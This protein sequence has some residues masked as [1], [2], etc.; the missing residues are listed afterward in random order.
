MPA[1]T[2]IIPL[3]NK[4]SYIGR[5]LDSVLHQ[6]FQDFEIIVVDDGSTDNGAEVVKSYDDPRIRLIR[7]ENKGVSVARNTG[8]DRATADFIAFLDADD[9]WMP[10]QLETVSGLRKKF[11]DAGLFERPMKSA[12]PMERKGPLIIIICLNRHGKEYWQIILKRPLAEILLSRHRPSE[13]Q[14]RY[15]KRWEDFPRDTGLERMQICTA[16]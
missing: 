5:A 1:A 12:R 14:K 7:Q 4:R 16:E 9:E 6:S 8:A 10:R 11:P 13:S 3:Y 2:I 15:F